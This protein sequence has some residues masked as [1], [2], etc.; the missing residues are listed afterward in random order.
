MHGNKGS[1]DGDCPAAMRYTECRLSN[2]GEM[3][4]NNIEKKIV[5]FIPNFDGSELEPTVLP[6]LYPNLLINGSNG[7]AAGYA[8]NIPPFNPNEVVDA[9]IAKIDSPNCRID[10][11]LSIMPAPD[12]PTSGI[13]SNLQG[14]KDAYKTGK[15]KILI[16]GEIVKLNSKQI[17]IT[18]IPFETNKSDI[19]KQIDLAKDK[20]DALNIIEVRDESDINGINIILETKTKSN[21]DFIKNYLYKNTKLQTSFNFNMVAIK[22]RKP[23]VLDI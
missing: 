14:V 4:I 7:I 5:K 18:S 8:T 2:F 22:D 16:S 9:I 12:F 11:I 1:I 17:A 20:I 10:K 19:I 15:G 13:I 21:F 23:V 3:L 6:T